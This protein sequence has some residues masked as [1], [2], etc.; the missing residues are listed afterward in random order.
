MNYGIVA[1]FDP[2]HNGHKYLVDTVKKENDTVTAVMSESF[3][4]R[5][6]CAC[7]RTGARVEA[8]LK[9]G[10]DLVV[11]LPLTFAVSSAENFAYGGVSVL[12]ALGFIDKIAFGSECGDSKLLSQCADALL[13]DGFDAEVVKELETG[14][15]Y[16]KARENALKNK[17]GDKFTKV[18]SSP[19]DTLGI[20]YIKALK[21]IDSQISFTAV[22]R[23]GA[24]HNSK[25]GEGSI[26]SATEIRSILKDGNIE[27]FVPKTAF[28]IYKSEIEK[29]KAPADYKSLE[30]AILSSLR[31]MSA[32]DFLKIPDVS[33]G[34]ENRLY[35]SVRNSA[36]LEDVLE[37]C[38][39]KR[40]THSRLRRIIL[41]SFLGITDEYRKI[42]VPYIRVLGFNEKGATLLKLAK[43][44][45]TLPVV[46]NQS[47]IKN[48]SREA[49]EY[50]S[51]ESKARD[52]FSL[53]LPESDVCGTLMTDKI[54]TVKG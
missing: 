48:L 14:V 2:F 37:K 27:N 26:R 4:Q 8:A 53:S 7:M 38:K 19:N 45:A 46:V 29:G 41:C 13:S 43:E 18:I 32:E 49:R 44:N 12:N 15:S 6:E 11:S 28:E 5:G 30:K 47:E 40:Y 20:E 17:Y 21:R 42:G 33:E 35:N 39:T 10:V 22:M 54:I 25:S 31:T 34:L 1:E 16:P 23:N 36:T 3:V 50:F 52:L 24:H 9:N 51:L